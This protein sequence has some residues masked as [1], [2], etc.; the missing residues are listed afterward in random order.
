MSFEFRQYTPDEF[1]EFSTIPPFKVYFSVP[2]SSEE[3]K[4]KPKRINSIGATRNI[5]KELIKNYNNL[6]KIN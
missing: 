6:R 3:K 1:L 2:L 5:I 4:K